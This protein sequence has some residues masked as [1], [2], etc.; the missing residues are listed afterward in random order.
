MGDIRVGDRVRVIRE[1]GIHGYETQAPFGSEH[2]VTKVDGAVVYL[3]DPDEHV[4][5]KALYGVPYYENEIEKIEPGVWVSIRPPKQPQPVPP[6][7]PEVPDA[8][9]GDLFVAKDKLYQFTY[10]GIV[11]KVEERSIQATCFGRTLHNNDVLEGAIFPFKHY[12]I[13]IL[14]IEV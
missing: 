7:P 8:R 5:V 2:I 6:P 3:S 12:D 9:V 11:T 4:P 1:G 13:S 14:D 10:H